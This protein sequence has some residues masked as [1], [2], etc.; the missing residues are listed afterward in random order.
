MAGQFAKNLLSWYARNR[1]NLPWVGESDPYRIWL[2]EII[3][4]QTRVEQGTAY[5]LRFIEEF[6]TV[7]HLAKAPETLVLKRWEGLGYYSRARNLHATAK[8]ITE[9]FKG[10]FPSSREELLKLKGIGQYTADAILSYAFK[11]PHAV[12]DGNVLRVLSRYKGIATPIDTPAGKA[13]ITALAD[14]Y[15][16]RSQPHI[17]N[18]AMMDFSAL[19]CTPKNPNCPECPFRTSCVAFRSGQTT[20]FP[21]KAKKITRK[22]RHLHFLICEKKGRILI[23][24]RGPKDIW[25][26][27][28]QFPLV[29]GTKT[30]SAAALAK[31]LNLNNAELTLL[32]TEKQLL[33]HQ[34]LQCTFWKVSGEIE[35]E[36][37]WVTRTQLKDY[38]F[39][40]A[41][42]SFMK[43]N[44]YF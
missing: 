39:P 22:T 36:G 38:A 23:Q 29:E 25:Q 14:Q 24:Q 16:D 27:L 12:T 7:A 4:Q 2:S 26:N 20:L 21:V 28:W 18:Q 6:P 17:Y 19:V 13:E 8:V 1:R 44:P 35:L 33:T 42:R 10:R 43:R 32:A 30:M 5:Y 31:S 40:G 34:Q 41:I 3:L 15:L 11:L 37:K 9:Q